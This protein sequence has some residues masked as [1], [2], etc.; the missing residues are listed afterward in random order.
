MT[1]SLRIAFALLLWLLPREASAH[2]ASPGVEGFTAAVI[3]ATTQ[4][5]APLALAA[6]GLLCGL[7]EEK[8]LAAAIVTFAGA[9]VL[10]LAVTLSARVH[11]GLVTPLTGLALLAGIHTA[12][13]IAPSRLTASALALAT[14]YFFGVLA[15]PDP[16]PISALAYWLAG[17]LVGACWAL[18]GIAAGVYMVRQRWDAPWLK[19]GLRVVGSWIV[20]IASLLITLHLAR[21][22]GPV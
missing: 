4:F 11:F 14:G 16:G 22:G 19:I 5:P 8:A 17:S 13:G 10:G 3:H 20:A 9:M 6:L 7:L 15:S 2:T 21:R 12:S 18:M 1:L